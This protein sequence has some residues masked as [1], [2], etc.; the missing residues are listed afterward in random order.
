MMDLMSGLRTVRP[1][2]TNTPVATVDDLMARIVVVSAANIASIPDL[3]EHARQFW[4]VGVGPAMT[5][6]AATLSGSWD[7]HLS[8]H[9]SRRTVIHCL[10]CKH[11]FCME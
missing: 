10:Y 6:E 11:A 3:H 8:L 2:S 7:N 9:F 1:A 5:Y 4:P